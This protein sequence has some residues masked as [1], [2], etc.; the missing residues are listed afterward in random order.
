MFFSLTPSVFE[1]ACVGIPRN[2]IKDAMY[3]YVFFDRN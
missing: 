2:I 1:V 3:I